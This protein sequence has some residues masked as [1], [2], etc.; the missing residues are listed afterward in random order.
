MASL[1]DKKTEILFESFI[2]WCPGPES[3]RHDRKVEGF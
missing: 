2:D 1:K 3:N